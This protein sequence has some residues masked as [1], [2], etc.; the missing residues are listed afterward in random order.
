MGQV[1]SLQDEHSR[2]PTCQKTLSLG[3]TRASLGLS[4]ADQ[5]VLE[6]RSLATWLPKGARCFLFILPT[7]PPNLPKLSARPQQR[8]RH[9][10]HSCPSRLV[11]TYSGCSSYRLDGQEQLLP[12]SD[13][14]IPD[15]H[16]YQQRRH[17]RQQ[18]VERSGAGTY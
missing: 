4:P 15:R 5:E 7:R 13:R 10:L 9:C 17:R 18:I 11:R 6:Q 3:L 8:V 12:S 16:H 14:G 2:R 1:E